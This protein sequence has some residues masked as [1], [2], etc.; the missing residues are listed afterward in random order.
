MNKE[1]FV[2]PKE[3]CKILG[4]HILSLK[5]WDK[6]GKI[7]CIRTPGGKRLYNIEKYLNDQ[8]PKKKEYNWKENL[9][10]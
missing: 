9:L 2:T 10:L 8:I 7:E 3:A 6:K 4:V 5:N 1:H